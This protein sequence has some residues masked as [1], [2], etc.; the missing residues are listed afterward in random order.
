MFMGYYNDAEQCVIRWRDMWFHTG[1]RG[2]FDSDGYF[3]FLGRVG[4]RIRR[5]GVNIS[6]EQI[7]RVAQQNPA[8][9]ECAAIAVPGELG[10]DDIKLCAKL[11][12]GASKTPDEIALFMGENLPKAMKVRYV[13]FFSA[14][15]KTQTEKIQRA[16]LRKLGQSGMTPETWDHDLQRYWT[17]T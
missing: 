3:Y 1:D 7:E 4:D 17:S 9:L 5:R 14:L 16:E 12:D 15:P 13:E 8:I 11:I 10:E 2:K 6:A